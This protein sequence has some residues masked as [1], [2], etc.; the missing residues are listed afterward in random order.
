[1]PSCEQWR[2]DE[3]GGGAQSCF[4]GS[5]PAPVLHRASQQMEPIEFCHGTP[6]CWRLDQIPDVDDARPL[7]CP[8]PRCLAPARNG[9]RIVLHGHGVRS[10]SVIVPPT[11]G[12]RP[13]LTECWCRRYRC[14]ACTAVISVLP[15]GVL[16][17]YLYSVFAI[18]MAFLQ[19]VEEPIGRGA[20]DAIA[21]KR[22]GM[23]PTRSWRP[24]VD[25]R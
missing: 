15:I 22:Q 25:W 20:T 18:V 19:V 2:T 11:M 12:E 14:T 6:V 1:M 3:G 16:P 13:N 23:N 7:R 9:S 8:R 10:R 17:R 4:A 21:Y 5:A 24:R